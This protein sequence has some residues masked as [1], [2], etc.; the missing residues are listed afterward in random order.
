V[1]E[2]SVVNLVVTYQLVIVLIFH[3][4]MTVVAEQTAITIVALAAEA[5]LEATNVRGNPSEH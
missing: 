4:I 3:Q 5:V 2:I 1:V